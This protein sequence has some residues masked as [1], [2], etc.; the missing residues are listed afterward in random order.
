MQMFDPE[1]I[2]LCLIGLN[3]WHRTSDNVMTL[4]HKRYIQHVYMINNLADIDLYLDDGTF[5]YRSVRASARALKFRGLL[6]LLPWVEM[7]GG[8]IEAKPLH[9]LLQ[10][11]LPKGKMIKTCPRDT[12]SSR[13]WEC[14]VSHRFD[15]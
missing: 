2:V 4:V 14:R 1:D 6:C 7:Q 8:G 3:V 10:K 5:L 9:A 15:W 13:R 11:H 12:Y